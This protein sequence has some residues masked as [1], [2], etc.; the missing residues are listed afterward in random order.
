[1]AWILRNDASAGVSRSRA[2]YRAWVAVFVGGVAFMFSS[3]DLIMVELTG[4]EPVAALSGSTL[5]MLAM[6]YLLM[7][8]A[9]LWAQAQP[10]MPR[11]TASS[12]SR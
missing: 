5:P 8:G 11:N 3:A 2:A 10:T 7:S 1:M 6:T 9:L 12:L 4:I